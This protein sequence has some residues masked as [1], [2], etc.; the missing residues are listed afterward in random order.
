MDDF[1]TM[2]REKLGL[3][4]ID[5]FQEGN[6]ICFSYGGFDIGIKVCGDRFFAEIDGM[7]VMFDAFEIRSGVGLEFFLD[8]MGQRE[9]VVSLPGKRRRK[10]WMKA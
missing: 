1:Q 10:S 7:R 8:F 3:H 4:G 2:V 5:S 6:G 9:L